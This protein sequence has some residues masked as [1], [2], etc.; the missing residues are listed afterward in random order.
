METLSREMSVHG[1]PAESCAQSGVDLAHAAVFKIQKWKV[2]TQMDLDAKDTQVRQC[3]MLLEQ[4]NSR[5]QEEL[6]RGAVLQDKFALKC[7]EADKLQEDLRHQVSVN[8]ILEDGIQRLDATLEKQEDFARALK[9]LNVQKQRELVS[10]R[11][12]FF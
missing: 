5:L 6:Q 11:Y 4:Q 8:T 1:A 2:E 9:D 12:G 3:E 7:K 10:F